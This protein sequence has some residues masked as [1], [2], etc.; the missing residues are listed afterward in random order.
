[1][2]DKLNQG[3]RPLIRLLLALLVVGVL[4]SGAV[5]VVPQ[6][7]QAQDETPQPPE[8]GMPAPG[9]L[10]GFERMGKPG[11]G[12]SG[13][14]D[15]YLAEALGITVEE[16]QAARAKAE[17]TML[18]QAVADGEITAEQAAMIKARE[19]LRSYIDREALTAKALG[20]SVEELQAARE[21]GKSMQA[22]IEE[23]GLDAD[24][25]REAMQTAYEEAVQQAVEDGVIT[26]AQAD[27][28]LSGDRGMG[29]FG[30]GKPGFGGRG[31]GH[32]GRGWYVQPNPDVQTT[33]EGGL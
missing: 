16:L 18:E 28:F 31:S 1:M 26:Q 14:Y 27:Q 25:V 4:I 20:I 22:L 21:E 17:Q 15:A 9:G 29:G 2:E 33:P 23:L 32:G 30:G 13:K 7:V 3:K 24:T 5:A 8:A 19:A 12:D 10:R 11:F 6:V